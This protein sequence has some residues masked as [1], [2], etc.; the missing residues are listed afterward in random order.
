MF[1]TALEELQASLGTLNDIATGHE[2][3]HALAQRG[4]QLPPSI[5][6]VDET[7]LLQAAEAAHERLGDAKRF[8]R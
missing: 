8:W 4:I 1:L 5:G 6:D 3:L 7:K 2:M